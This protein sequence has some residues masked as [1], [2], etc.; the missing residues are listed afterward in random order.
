MCVRIENRRYICFPRSTTKEI[1]R[2]LKHTGPYLSSKADELNIRF[3]NA[4]SD[5]PILST[6]LHTQEFASH[7]KWIDD[8]GL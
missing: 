3:T 5:L 1:F 7:Y 8:G 2:I 4:K 6:G